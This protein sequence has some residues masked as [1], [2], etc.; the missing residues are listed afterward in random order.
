MPEGVSM[1]PGRSRLVALARLARVGVALGVGF[2]VAGCDAAPR[3]EAGAAALM[4]RH[5]CAG[6]H[7]IP[8]VD[9]ASSSVGPPLSG[10][11]KRVY[12]G[13]RL[14][15]A[16]NVAR[17]I[18]NPSAHRPSAMPN[19]GVQPEEAAQIAAYLSQLR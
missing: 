13:G 4:S 7:I 15:T 14:N 2:V 18:V 19:L 8:G 1:K 16:H 17:F 11:G 10:L 6:C 3:P 5:G 12:V 9:G